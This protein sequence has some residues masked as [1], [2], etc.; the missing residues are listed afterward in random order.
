MLKWSQIVTIQ[1]YRPHPFN[2]H[3]FFLAK[4]RTILSASFKTLIGASLQR[5]EAAP[6]LAVWFLLF[7]RP[8]P[9]A[10]Q[11]PRV[12]TACFREFRLTCDLS[13]HFDEFELHENITVL[14]NIRL[15]RTATFAGS[16]LQRLM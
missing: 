13:C 8:W 7:R 2:F 4:L 9:L 3:I 14:C 1:F 10:T 5:K 11:N 16:T 15:K 6:S 12:A